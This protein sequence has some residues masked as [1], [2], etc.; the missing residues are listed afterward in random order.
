MKNK[1][2]SI[3]ILSMLLTSCVNNIDMLEFIQ[4]KFPYAKV[5]YPIPNKDYNFIL[6][7]SCGGIYHME[8]SSMYHRINA[9]ILIKSC[10]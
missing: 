1:L 4:K 5:I 7:D 10:N 3:I 8:T 6:V 9:K 2:L